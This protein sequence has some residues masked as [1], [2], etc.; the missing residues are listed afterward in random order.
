MKRFNNATRALL[1]CA[2]LTLAVA[3]VGQVSEAWV[4]RYN[5]P[6]NSG[7]VATKL[8]VD[9]AGNVYVTGYSVGVGSSADYATIRYDSNGNQLWVARYN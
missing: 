4:A 9:A 5:G 7:D 8:A 2:F 6:G 3:G 1:G